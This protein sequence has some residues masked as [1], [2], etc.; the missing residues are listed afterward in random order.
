MSELEKI[1]SESYTPYLGIHNFDLYITTGCNLHCGD[2]MAGDV[3]DRGEYHAETR[4][5]LETLEKLRG[6]NSVHIAGQGEPFYHPDAIQI[7]NY[8]GQIVR[9]E[10]RVNTNATCMPLDD[11]SAER[12]IASLPEKLSVF[13]SLDRFHDTQDPYAKKRVDN[14]KKWCGAYDMP[15]TFSLRVFDK[16][17]E[18]Q[19]IAKHYRLSRRT[20]VVNRVLR[21]GWAKD[22]REAR[23]VDL[24]K[25]FDHLTN[26][27]GYG[28]LPDGTVVADFVPAYLAEDAR[29]AISVVGNAKGESLVSMFAR[30]KKWEDK[31]GKKRNEHL[32]SMIKD[33][34]SHPFC[35]SN[36]REYS[37][38]SPPLKEFFDRAESGTAKVLGDKIFKSS[39][40]RT[41][42]VISENGVVH[43]GH[44]ELQGREDELNWGF[45]KN[46][47]NDEF[48]E[49]DR[50]N[51][52][53]L[54]RLWNGGDFGY[55]ESFWRTLIEMRGERFDGGDAFREFLKIFA[56]TEDKRKIV[57]YLNS[58]KNLLGRTRNMPMPLRF[59]HSYATWPYN[60]GKNE[61]RE[62]ILQDVAREIGYKGYYF[63]AVPL[64]KGS[65]A[66]SGL[67]GFMEGMISSLPLGFGS[68]LETSVPIAAFTIFRGLSF[69]AGYNH[70]FRGKV[71]L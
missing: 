38:D 2:C 53:Q 11:S 29:P 39:L 66:L 34:G 19:D 57:G 10:V 13:I 55:G 65:I 31:A 7:L 56:D 44:E 49:G 15:L 27:R 26:N 25:L 40:T 45:W 61:K 48:T 63:P 18:A 68:W 70:K 3:R 64:G 9:D 54:Q 69:Y 14:F 46:L 35:I 22:M 43:Y 21:M 5:V 36:W 51:V 1:N 67:V 32:A 42:E 28:I 52:L 23:Y 16:K 4:F 6:I 8:A 33:M 58:Q 50:E 47:Y 17:G 60:F 24:T 12:F 62:K 71:K 59:L 20:T 30:R 41:G 37:S